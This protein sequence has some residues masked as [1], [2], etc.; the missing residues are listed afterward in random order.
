MIDVIDILAV[1][2]YGWLRVMSPRPNGLT[3]RASGDAIYCLNSGHMGS[4]LH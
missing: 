4:R 2:D 1:P 3:R